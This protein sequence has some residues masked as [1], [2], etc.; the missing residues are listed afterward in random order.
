MRI[1]SISRAQRG[2]VFAI[3]ALLVLCW[4]PDRGHGT[5]LLMKAMHWAVDPLDALPQ[6]PPALPPGLGDNGDAVAEH[7]AIE[8]DYYRLHNSSAMTRWRM[9]MEAAGDPFDPTTERQVLIAIA[10]IAALAV[11][12][13]GRK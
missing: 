2:I 4:P 6:L 9:D 12:M 13:V 1:S 7:D 10:V 11:W 8:A 5:S 3:A